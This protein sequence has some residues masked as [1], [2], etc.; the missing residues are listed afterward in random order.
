MEDYTRKMTKNMQN[1]MSTVFC[2]V[3]LDLMAVALDFDGLKH[4]DRHLNL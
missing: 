4:R 3:I 2:L 1:R